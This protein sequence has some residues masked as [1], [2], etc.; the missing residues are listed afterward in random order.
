MPTPHTEDNKEK[1]RQCPVTLR[2]CKNSCKVICLLYNQTGSTPPADY[3]SKQEVK[4]DY[5]SGSPTFKEAVKEILD[6]Q[7][8][9]AYNLG[10]DHAIRI[11]QAE[12]GIWCGEEPAPDR[13]FDEI[14]EKIQ[15]LKK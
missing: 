5:T 7:R 6:D 13:S 12:Q 4:S 11:V 1:P 3:S 9:D 15:S 10:L 2:D 14:I 8:N